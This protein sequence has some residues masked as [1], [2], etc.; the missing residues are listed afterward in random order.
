VKFGE[1]DMNQNLSSFGFVRVAAVSP[2]HKVAGVEFNTGQIINSIDKAVEQKCQLILFPELCITGYTCADLFYQST[3]LVNVRQAIDKIAKHTKKKNVTVVVGAPISNAGRL[4]NCAVLLSSGDVKGI[5]PKTYLCNTN[6]YYEERWFSSEFDR[7]NDSIDWNGSEVPF[8]ADILFKINNKDELIIGIELCE[9]LWSVIPP[10]FNM[11]LA[12][13][14][15]LLNLSAGDEVLGKAK[16]RRELVVSQ[17]ARCLA[18]YIY[19]GCGPGESSTD[20]V[21]SGHSLIAE[22]GIILAESERFKF[23]TNM[24]IS[25][26]DVEKLFKERI[27]NNSFGSSVPEF[28][29]RIVNINVDELKAPDL[30][31]IISSKPFIPEDETV[32]SETCRE[33]FSIQTTGLAKRLLYLKKP[34]VVIGVSGGLDS[35]LALIV[36]VRTFHKLK[37]N[38]LKIHAFT[39]PGFGTSRRTLANAQNLAEKLGVSCKNI[40]I[41]DAVQKHFKNIGHDGKTFDVVYENSQAR[42]RMQILMDIANKYNGIVIG[43]GD[44]SEL[45][46]GWSTYNGDHMSMYGVNAGVPKTLV[47]YIIEWTAKTEFSG[48]ITS[49]LLD[50]INTPISP[51]L[52]PEDDEGSYQETEKSIGPYILHD[53]FLYYAVRFGFSPKKIL[54]LANQAFAGEFSD[55]DISKFLRIF[56]ERFFANQFKRSCLPDGVKVGTVALSPRGDWRMSSDSIPDDWLKEINDTSK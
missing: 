49:I 40:S 48:E 44:L 36:A 45:A 8:G 39:M 9:D 15:I 35:A 7:V 11:A 31:R 56:I 37:M 5:I 54:M 10:S 33:I 20:M 55:E 4:Y 6:E 30:I 13:A 53:F 14:A 32:R 47:K 24:I 17:S 19:A 21:F 41:N 3:L 51:E 38:P 27:K 46:L 52:I 22:N 16:Y 28:D 23:D 42:E 26:I 34:P 50:I 18:A 1:K 29:Y 43:T 12:G 25:D 2:E